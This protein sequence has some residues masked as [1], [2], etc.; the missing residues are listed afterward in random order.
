[1]TLESASL[2]NSLLPHIPGNPGWHPLGPLIATPDEQDEAEEDEDE[3]EADDDDDDDDEDDAAE[4]DE[5]A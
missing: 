5:D 1:M 4:E 2:E 3:D